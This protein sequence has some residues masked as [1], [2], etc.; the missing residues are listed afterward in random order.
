MARQFVLVHGMS[1]RAWWWEPLGRRL[2]NNGHRV[3]AMDLPGHGRRAH[4]RS[5][6]S[7]GTERVSMRRFY[8]MHVPSTYVRC[9]RDAA[10]TPIDI[11]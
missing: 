4:E 9:L 2:E 7:V 8:A 5:R 10:V 3:V 1:H 6:A 11:D